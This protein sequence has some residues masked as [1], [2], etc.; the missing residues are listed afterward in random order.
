MG[1][2]F[3]PMIKSTYHIILILNTATKLFFPRIRIGH[4]KLTHSYLIKG[5]QQPVCIFCD[6]PLTLHHIFLE[7]SDTLPARN[8][9]LHNVQ[10]MQDLITQVNI[11]DILQ[12]LQECDFYNKIKRFLHFYMFYIFYL[13]L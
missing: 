6:C 4:S 2:T 7:C 1:S 9:L 10:T 13:K 3:P 5:E 11:S 12:I 8:L